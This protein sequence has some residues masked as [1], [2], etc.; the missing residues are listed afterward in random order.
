MITYAPLRRW[1]LT[2][3][4]ALPV[5]VAC[6]GQVPP[7]HSAGS[8]SSASSASSAE[9]DPALEVEELLGAGRRFA[10]AGDS[11]R[12]EHYLVAALERGGAP[13]RV[14]PLLVT[15]C[16]EGSRLRAALGYAESHL[17]AHPEDAQL[18]FLIATLY[19][20]LD[21]PRE[22]RLA[23]ERLLRRR[24]DHA[25]ARYLLGSL[26]VVTEPTAT[27]EHFTRYLELEPQGAHAPEVRAWLWDRSSSPS[28]PGHPLPLDTTP[29]LETT[30][31]DP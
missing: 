1:L 24:P 14:M 15:V 22:A 20:G 3:A 6:A 11:V 16:V 4:C 31:H 9:L 19:L 12:A 30:R 8:T 27:A 26:L 10:H 29:P 17:R 13:D 7:V 23:L 28:A 25:R 5:V 21:R 2:P 18:H